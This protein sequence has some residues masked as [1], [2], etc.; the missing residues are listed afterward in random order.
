[1]S[2]QSSFLRAAGLVMLALVLVAPAPPLAAEKVR[3]AIG[4]RGAPQYEL[5]M[6]AAQERAFWKEQ[7]LEVEPLSFLGGGPLYRAMAA[8]HIEISLTQVGSFMEAATGGVPG[9]IVAD[10]QTEF[11]FLI[12]VRPDSRIKKAEDLRG[13]KIGMARG[14]A[15]VNGLVI[16]R[17]LGIEK[18]VRFVA[19]G[20]TAERVA[21][22]KAGAID[23]FVQAFPPMAELV[24]KG[25]FRSV[26]S[27]K[28]F[29]AKGATTAIL[30]AH[31][32]FARKNPET[33]KRAVKGMLA[34]VT[35]LQEN[36]SW[37]VEKMRSALGYS[38][39]A[40]NLLF[41][42]LSFGKDGKIDPRVVENAR[43]FLIEYGIVPREKVPPAGQLYTAEFTG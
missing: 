13:A 3:I 23:A 21:A 1:M 22:A 31:K 40:A 43:N 7:N 34:A 17:G 18:E 35:F 10:M 16:V 5:P 2:R 8:G 27:A 29:L 32:D 36:R 33:V 6:A 38:A 4:L 28:P 11:P 9:V 15:H 42:Q 26:A 41:E 30:V 20:G 24:V 37:S 39:E 25:E 19:V 14:A 12:W